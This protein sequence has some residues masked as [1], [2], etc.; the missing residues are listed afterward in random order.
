VNRLGLIAWRRLCRSKPASPGHEV[1]SEDMTQAGI[2]EIMVMGKV[3][4]E[5]MTF[6]TDPM[7]IPGKLGQKIRQKS[8]TGPGVDMV[9]W[10]FG[11]AEL[12]P[13]TF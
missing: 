4:R 2:T 8:L 1:L 5:F 9:H 7:R 3:Y 6:F 10:C 13:L 11:K 12:L